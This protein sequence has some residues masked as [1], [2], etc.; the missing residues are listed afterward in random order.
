[1]QNFSEVFPCYRFQQ[2]CICN[3]TWHTNLIKC[4][5]ALDYDVT[6]HVIKT[7]QQQNLQNFLDIMASKRKHLC[8]CVLLCDCNK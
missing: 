4:T 7:C 3:C 1:M 8:C 2:A 5:F 6:L